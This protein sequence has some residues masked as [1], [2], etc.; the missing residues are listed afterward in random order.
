MSRGVGAVAEGG[1][2]DSYGKEKVILGFSGKV[3]FLLLVTFFSLS[4]LRRG[5]TRTSHVGDPITVLL[6]LL[7]DS[8]AT[9][10]TTTTLTSDTTNTPAALPRVLLLLLQVLPDD[11]QESCRECYLYYYIHLLPG[12][13]LKYML[14]I[15]MGFLDFRCV[16]ADRH[17]DTQTDIVSPLHPWSLYG[18]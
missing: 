14:C 11:C 16:A 5:G 13:I 3:T 10:A 2:R 17:A 1:G 6:L 15:G 9:S 8:P 7:L 12:A 18:A 4:H